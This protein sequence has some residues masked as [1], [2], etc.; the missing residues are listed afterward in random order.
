MLSTAE[1]FKNFI[2][3]LPPTRD[4]VEGVNNFVTVI[5]NFTNSVQAG[6]TGSPG[7]LTFGNSA[8]ISALLTM[9][10]V[11]DNSWIQRFADAWESGITTSIITPGTVI[12]PVWLGSAGLDIA[13]VPSASATILTIPTA[14]AGLITEL[15][16]SDL[17]SNSPLPLA[18]AI[19]NATLALVFNCIGLGPPPFFVPIPIPLSAQ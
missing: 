9:Q 18:T 8:M 5:A 16:T 13:T 19:R 4:S 1:D 12:E 14:K 11:K 2:L 15:S 7:I 17:L 6:P 10:P 3:S